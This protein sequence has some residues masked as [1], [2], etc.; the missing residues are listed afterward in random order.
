MTVQN[1]AGTEGKVVSCLHFAFCSGQKV[2]D[3]EVRVETSTWEYLVPQGT[4]VMGG[5]LNWRLGCSW[6]LVC[7]GQ[8]C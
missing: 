8:A 7:R 4:M 3:I 6:H 1:S 2:N 5:R